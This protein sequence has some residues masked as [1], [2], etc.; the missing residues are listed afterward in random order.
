[1]RALA[2]LLTAALLAL[3]AWAQDAPI[4][5]TIQSQLDAFIADDFATAFTFASPTIKG[6]FGTSDNFGMM[7]R[8]GYPMVHRPAD[9]KML[10]LR[11][12]AGNLWQRVMITDQQGRTHMLDYQMIE[13]AD[14]WQINGVQLLPSPGVG[15]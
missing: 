11:E 15:A 3:P 2:G 6:L 14:G 12:V 9:V 7:V 5:N 1:M 8:N 10:E 4:Q 13:T